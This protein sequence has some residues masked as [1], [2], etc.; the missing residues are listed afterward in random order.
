[1]LP[2]RLVN[3]VSVSCACAGDG[4]V[5]RPPVANHTGI[6]I[7]EERLVV[8][9]LIA[10]GPTRATR[11]GN[12]LANLHVVRPPSESPFT[13]SLSISALIYFTIESRAA[14]TAPS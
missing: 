9:A 3:V 10:D 8:M 7:I 1:M 13:K 2:P 4:F 6:W 14:I 5:S 11:V 12:V